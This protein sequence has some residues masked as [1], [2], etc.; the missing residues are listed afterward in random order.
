MPL[1]EAPIVLPELKLINRPTQIL[2]RIPLWDNEEE[3]RENSYE[4]RDL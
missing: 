3:K 2:S 1:P 4:V